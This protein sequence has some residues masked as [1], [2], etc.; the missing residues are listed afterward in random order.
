[1]SRN[2]VD[3]VVAKSD[4]GAGLLVIALD[5][6]DASSLVCSGNRIRSRVELGATV[7]LWSLVECT[8]TG[9]IV[10]NEI[11]NAKNDRS[12]V[13]EPHLIGKVAAVAVTGNVLIG[14]AQL[15]AR[16]NAAPFDTW[17]GLNTITNYVGP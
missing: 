14:Q 6:T 11:A 12:L 10:S 2:Q 17:N 3:A 13:L 7:S 16:P 1:V 5:T 8:F 9:N 4:S 15:P